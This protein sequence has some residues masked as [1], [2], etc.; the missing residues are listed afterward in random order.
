MLPGISTS[1]RKLLL[2]GFALAVAP[3]VI[4]LASTVLQVDRLASTMQKTMANSTQA[5]ESSRLI[6]SQAL[7]LERSAEQYLLLGD[8]ALLLRYESLRHRLAEEIGR[9][10][11]LTASQELDLRLDL[12]TKR[13]EALYHRLRKTDD[14]QIGKSR[15]EPEERLSP[16]VKPIPFDVSRMVGEKAEAMSTRVSEV[17]EQL[18]W[19]AAALIPLALILAALFGSLIARPLR[20]LSNA[21]RRLAEG[22]FDTPVEVRGPQDIRALGQELEWMRQQLAALD[23]QKMQFLRHVSHELKTP[24]TTIREGAGLLHEEIT[25]QL[26][27]E[28]REVTR[29]LQ[30]S[31]HQL[32]DQVESLLN[33]NLALAQQQPESGVPLDLEP[34]LRD[35]LQKHMLPAQARGIT[36]GLQAQSAWICG[37]EGQI[38]LIIDNLLSNAVKYTPDRG[39]IEIR[40]TSRNQS[41]ELEV[42]NSGTGIPGE[43]RARVFEPFYRGRSKAHGPIRGTGLGLSIVRHYTQLNQGRVELLESEQGACFR[44]TFPAAEEEKQCTVH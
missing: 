12:L 43:E 25:G 34:L 13:E 37:V 27:E 20:Q 6:A 39:V 26:T 24:L 19:Q 21:I 28:Q 33:F 2:L 16:V 3:L 35:T 38:Q 31:S 18:L 15:L 7:S 5:V 17:Q 10:R 4:G 23:E 41:V 11:S 30:E 32:Q 22:R 14:S 29:I 8:V 36:V 40:L 44:V 42:S 9:L 1:I